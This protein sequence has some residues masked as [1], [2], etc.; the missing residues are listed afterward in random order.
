MVNRQMFDDF[1]YVRSVVGGILHNTTN[2]HTMDMIDDTTIWLKKLGTNNADKGKSLLERSGRLLDETTGRILRLDL[3]HKQNVLTLTRWMTQEYND[4]R[5]KDNMDL[6]QKRLRSVEIL[7]ALFTF[8]LSIRA[9]HLM[10]LGKRATIDNYR[11]LFS[12]PGDI[13]LQLI[14]SSGVQRYNDIVNDLDFLSKFKYTGL[15]WCTKTS[16]IAG[17][18]Y[19]MSRRLMYPY[20]LTAG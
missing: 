12:F 7:S 18:F 14:S 9:N 4:L 19:S 3:Y 5:A 20:T 10:G 17:N 1:I 13:M 2:R 8:S 16:L 11:D 6:T 15:L